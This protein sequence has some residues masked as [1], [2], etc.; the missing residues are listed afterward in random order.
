MFSKDRTVLLVSIS[1]RHF[2]GSHSTWLRTI[3]L[4]NVFVSLFSKVTMK[5]A[6]IPDA[7]INITHLLWSYCRCLHIVAKVAYVM[8][9]R[10]KWKTLLGNRCLQLISNMAQ[11]RP[12]SHSWIKEATKAVV[13]CHNARP[14]RVQTAVECWQW[15]SR[16]TW[17]LSVRAASDMVSR[18]LCILRFATPLTDWKR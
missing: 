3:C 2:F 8:C 9:E 13:G 10:L 5:L 7:V 1:K 17:C 14:C 11:R 18:A 16:G 4:C 12:Y 6:M 15:W